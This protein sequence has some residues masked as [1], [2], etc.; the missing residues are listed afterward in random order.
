MANETTQA[1]W[2]NAK[3]LQLSEVLSAVPMPAND[4][5]LVKHQFV[6]MDSIAGEP[7]EKKR[8]SRNIKTILGAAAT[9]NVALATNTAL[10]YENVVDVSVGENSTLMSTI[11]DR[12]FERKLPGRSDVPSILQSQDPVAILQ[13][14]G[15]DARHHNLGHM[16]KAESDLIALNSTL[17]NVIG[18]ATT[19]FSL[20][21]AIEAQWKLDD[22]QVGGGTRVFELAPIQVKHLR[23]QLGVTGG[24]M[25]GSIWGGGADG[26]VI[27]RSGQ[28]L[29]NGYCFSILG[30]PIYQVAKDFQDEGESD[31]VYGAY[32]V[33]GDGPPEGLDSAQKSPF[34]LLEGRSSVTYYAQMDAKARSEVLVSVYVYAAAKTLDARGVAV[35]SQDS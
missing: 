6:N 14:L 32:Y 30:D 31:D 8:Y 12:A 7:T 2:S 25:G 20:A 22:L 26:A 35:R 9:E 10:T 24:G 29:T 17:T 34:V 4:P 13:L 23:L 5:T 19:P 28:A 16:Q 27:N 11:T 18:T 1:I 21:S 15:N 3:G 33:I